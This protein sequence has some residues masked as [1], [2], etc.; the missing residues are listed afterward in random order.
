MR[1]VTV[2]ILLSLLSIHS[3]FALCKLNN[4]GQNICTDEKALY[5]VENTEKSTKSVNQEYEV[6]IVK[7][8]VFRERTVIVKGK[9]IGEKEVHIDQLIGNKLCDGDNDPLCKGTK[10]IIR[11]ECVDPKLKAKYKVDEKFENNVIELT[12][13]TILFSKSFLV[14]DNCIDVID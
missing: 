13:G 12:T 7:K 14:S 3:A 11:D 6:V 5:I 10:V 8:H 2:F 9:T 1:Q 4:L